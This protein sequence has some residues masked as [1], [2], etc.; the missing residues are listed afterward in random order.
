MM[1]SELKFQQHDLPQETSSP[2]NSNKGR[3]KLTDLV[4]RMNKEKKKEKQSNLIISVAAISV[5]TAF[6]IILSI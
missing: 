1:S 3:V 5:V 2:D 6:G 4:A